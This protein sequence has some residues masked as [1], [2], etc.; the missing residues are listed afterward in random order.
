MKCKLIAYA[1]P[2][3]PPYYANAPAKTAWKC[4]THNW[5]MDYVVEDMCPIGKIEDATDKAIEKINETAHQASSGLLG[6]IL[7]QRKDGSDSSIL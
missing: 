7:M 4:E 6:N 1:V 5:V 3:G 2:D